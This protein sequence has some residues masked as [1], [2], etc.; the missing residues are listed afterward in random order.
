MGR[1][2]SITM[3]S[4]VGIVGR[5][6]A[7]DEKSVMFLLAGLRVAQRHAGIVFTQ[8][9]KNWFFAQQGRHVAPI[10]VKFGTGSGPQVRSP[11]PVPTFTFIRA[12]MWKYSSQN[13]QNFEFWP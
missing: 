7:V 10:N 5:A 1:T 4:M 6:P 2:F 9:S 13:C 11:S 12:K 3:P 8:W